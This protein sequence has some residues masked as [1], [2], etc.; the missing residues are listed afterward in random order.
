MKSLKKLINA[1]FIN[2]IN[3]KNKLFRRGIKYPNNCGLLD[4]Y[5]N[6]TSEQRIEIT[7]TR[8]NYFKEQ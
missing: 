1:S 8:D 3:K 6:L 4:C 7:L 5:E 2:K